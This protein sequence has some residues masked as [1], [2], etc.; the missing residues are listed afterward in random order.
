M[1]DR[2]F[3]LLSA[4]TGEVFAATAEECRRLLIRPVGS[5]DSVRAELDAAESEAARTGQDQPVASPEGEPW[6]V[7]CWKARRAN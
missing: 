3:L 7:S 6:L 2:K 4:F 5:E 1:P